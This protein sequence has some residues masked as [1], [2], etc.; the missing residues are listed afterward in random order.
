MGM[1]YDG[2]DD[3]AIVTP[4]PVE[5]RP[6]VVPAE[7]RP[8]GEADLSLPSTTEVR[9]VWSFTVTPQYYLLCHKVRN[10]QR[11][12]ALVKSLCCV[13][14]CTICSLVYFS[15][16]LFYT[17]VC[18]QIKVTHTIKYINSSNIQTRLH[19]STHCGLWL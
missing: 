13:P 11:R 6:Y 1:G 16:S 18:K 5:A 2:L 4:I 15:T 8:E 12:S 7:Q 17:T 9:N 10:K 19:I 14:E 3:W